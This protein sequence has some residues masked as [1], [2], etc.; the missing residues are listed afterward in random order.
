MGVDGE[1]EKCGIEAITTFKNKGMKDCAHNLEGRDQTL[2][3]SRKYSCALTPRALFQVQVDDEHF[4]R[5]SYYIYCT[6]IQNICC[7]SFSNSTSTQNCLTF[8]TYLWNTGV[9]SSLGGHSDHIC[10]PAATKG[11]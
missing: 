11:L 10:L 2:H 3:A 9:V 1:K 4:V 6:T 5:Q 8:S 7:V